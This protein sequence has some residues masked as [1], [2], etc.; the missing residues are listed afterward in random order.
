MP[1]HTPDIALLR[2]LT[3]TYLA[4]PADT[5]VNLAEI[6]EAAISVRQTFAELEALLAQSPWD[7]DAILGVLTKL[8]L[9]LTEHIPSHVDGLAAPLDRIITLMAE[10]LEEE[11]GDCDD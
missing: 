1:N 7:K 9:E 8:Q 4:E 10:E 11:E 3:S 5:T 6:C 2:K